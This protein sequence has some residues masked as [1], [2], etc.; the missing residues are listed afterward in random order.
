MRP[1]LLSDSGP[2]IRFPAVLTVL[3]LTAACRA[4]PDRTESATG[5][6]LPTGVTLDPAGRMTDLGPLPLS[7][8]MS[9]DGG[10]LVALL[11]GWREQ[12]VQIIDRTTG[13]VRQT[14]TQPS[15][16]LGLAFAPDGKTLYASGGGADRVY[17]YDWTGS[18]ATLRDSIVLG[19]G[20]GAGQRYVSGL[21]VSRDGGRLYVAL[22]LADSLAVV[23]PGTGRE[24]QRLPTGRYPYAVVTGPDGTVYVSAW[25]GEAIN[26]F[27]AAAAGRLTRA[28]DLPGGRHPSALLLNRDGSRLFAVSATT[29]LITVLDTRSGTVAATLADPPPAG[30]NEGTTPNALAL[31]VDGRHLYAAEADA[32]AV[33]VFGLSAASAGMPEARGNDSLMGRIPVGWYPSAVLATADT[34]L[35][36]NGK[37]TRAGPNPGGPQP[38]KRSAARTDYTLGQISG[39]LTRLRFDPADANALRDYSRRVAHANGWDRERSP[40]AGYP[41]FEH[42]IYIIKENRTY[43][44]LFGDLP[45]GDGDSALV[46]FPREVTPNHHALAERFGLFDRFFVNAEVSADGHNWST[47]AYATDYVEK[48]VQSNYSSGGRDYDYEGE[49]RGVIAEDDVN[50]PANGYLWDLA[51]RAGISLRN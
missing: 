37:G 36:V 51:E 49:N 22:N 3:A 23:D 20:R 17:R 5:A 34:L 29:N 40:A 44:Q 25:G 4:A 11:C 26:V 28:A 14:L 6:A 8:V 18:R 1:F 24:L 43:D 2:S 9:P 39:T 10:S 46:F 21:A 45:I 15:A 31:S 7:M 41:P 32:N 33:A 48:T 16:F 13:T 47:A 19:P 42:V 50:E 27:P 38:G 35:V 30:P 12:G